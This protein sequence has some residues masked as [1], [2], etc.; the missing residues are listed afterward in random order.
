[1][2]N[3]LVSTCVA[4]ISFVVAQHSIGAQTIDWKAIGDEAIKLLQEYVRIDTSN[5]PGDTRKAAD[6]LAA[7]FEREGI[8]VTRYESAPGK[9]IVYA[10]LKA[11]TSPAAGK[12]IV[13]LHHMD[14][15]PADRSQ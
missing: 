10:R 14:V 5:P 12:P 15:V 1:M 2:K 4:C 7:I 6:F 11:T 13:L 9:A 3:R 8:P